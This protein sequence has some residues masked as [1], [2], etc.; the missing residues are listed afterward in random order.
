MNFV[1]KREPL[2]RSA[3]KKSS[4]LNYHSFI[5]NIVNNLPAALLEKFNFCYSKIFY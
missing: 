2:K 5:V 4:T 1:K 3:S